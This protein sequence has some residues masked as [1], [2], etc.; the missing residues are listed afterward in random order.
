MCLV[1]HIAETLYRQGLKQSNK[2]VVYNMILIAL[3]DLWTKIEGVRI[4][5]GLTLILCMLEAWQWSSALESV[6]R[7]RLSA[8]KV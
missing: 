6:I 1:K 2:F 4:A 8:I 7:W 5:R 3:T